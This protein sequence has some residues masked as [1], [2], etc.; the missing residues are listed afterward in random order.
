MTLPRRARFEQ[1]AHALGALNHPNIVAIST[2]RNDDGRAYIV[3]ELVE[4]E[5]LRAMLD[6]GPVPV[7]KTIDLAGQIADG[8]A[9]AHALRHRAP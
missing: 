1:E 9:A 7:R 4:G 8:M 6:R 5:S 3:S 2:M